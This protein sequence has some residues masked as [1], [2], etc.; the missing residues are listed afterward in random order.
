M[1][2]IYI[3]V[4]KYIEASGLV[5]V[6]NLLGLQCL[7]VWLTF[8]KNRGWWCGWSIACQLL[9]WIVQEKEGIVLISL[10]MWEAV[11]VSP[12]RYSMFPMISSPWGFMRLMRFRAALWNMLRQ[13]QTSDVRVAVKAR[14]KSPVTSLWVRQRRRR[15][16]M[17]W[18]L[19]H[20]HY[21]VN[22]L[23]SQDREKLFLVTSSVPKDP[24]GRKEH[25]GLSICSF[26]DL[27]SNTKV[28]CWKAVLNPRGF[29]QGA[30]E[31]NQ[32]ASGGTTAERRDHRRTG[33]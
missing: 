30:S 4:V 20:G 33:L 14:R 27:V 5:L 13:C 23:C 15:S 7:Q 29:R 10:S 17:E 31:T 1:I 25:L 28:C 24:Q 12:I 18:R 32:S 16:E 22:L 2:Y 19:S 6:A 9:P 26:P 21:D 8:W 3:Y 11:A